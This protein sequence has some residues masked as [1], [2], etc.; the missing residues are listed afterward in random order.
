[1]NKRLAGMMYDR[2]G[3]EIYYILNN[4]S[5]YY[6]ED[7][8]SRQLDL[9]VRITNGYKDIDG[10]EYILCGI[11][12]ELSLLIMQQKTLFNAASFTCDKS[13]TLYL[14]KGNGAIK[15][16]VSEIDS[17]YYSALNQ[18]LRNTTESSEEVPLRQIIVQGHYTDIKDLI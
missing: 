15:Y 17:V 6:I 3:N 4:V 9:E 13:F 7:V 11:D 16:S 5:P 2:L 1:M 14:G 12:T 8:V 18:R 10:Y